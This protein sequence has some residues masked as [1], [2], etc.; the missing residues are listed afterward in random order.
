M[1][2]NEG[3]II[4]DVENNTASGLYAVAEGTNTQATGMYSHAEGR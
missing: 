1:I 2:T 3:V 4:G